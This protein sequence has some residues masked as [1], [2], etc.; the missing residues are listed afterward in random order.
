MTA[1]LSGS[2]A[3][4]NVNLQQPPTTGKWV[5]RTNYGMDGGAHPVYSSFRN[6]EMK[7]DLISVSDLQQI[8]NVYNAVGNTGTV[9]TCLP[10]WGASDF[11]FFNYSGT[12]L[13]EPEVGEYYMG[14]VQNV[15]LLVINARTN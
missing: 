5:G 4:D 12:T 1:G 3:F 7:W 14:F 15:T 10:Q 6:F 11:S 13:Q 8:I 9:V 2:Y